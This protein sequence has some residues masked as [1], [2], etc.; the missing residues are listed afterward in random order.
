LVVASA[1]AVWPA[2]ASLR[3]ASAA[4]AELMALEPPRWIHNLADLLQ[5]AT[6]VAAIAVWGTSR[7]KR[8]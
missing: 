6:P 3:F 1:V 8:R 5:I 4:I 7:L 2:V